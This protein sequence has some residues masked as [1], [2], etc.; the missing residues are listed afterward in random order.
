[1]DSI[2]IQNLFSRI[3]KEKLS[4]RQ[5]EALVKK[6]NNIGKTRKS[7]NLDSNFNLEDEAELSAALE[8]KVEISNKKN[9]SG[10][11][12]IFFKSSKDRTRIIDIIKSSK[13]K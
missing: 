5:T 4:V 2:Q 6:I 8:S 11:I 3:V 7:L 1:M 13:T 10:N 12:K 9:N